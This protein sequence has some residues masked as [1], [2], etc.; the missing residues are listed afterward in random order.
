MLPLSPIPGAKLLAEIAVAHGS[1]ILVP[2]MVS[3]VAISALIHTLI[4]TNNGET[5]IVLPLL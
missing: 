5:L 1:S 2:E 3:R 4:Y